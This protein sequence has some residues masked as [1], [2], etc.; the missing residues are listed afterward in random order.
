M[1][2]SLL[3]SLETAGRGDT[4]S[5]RNRFPIT[6]TCGLERKV[7]LKHP[8]PKILICTM[9]GRDFLVGWKFYCTWS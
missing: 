5:T 3:Q 7:V 6:C 1:V 9:K 8:I 2:L 4:F